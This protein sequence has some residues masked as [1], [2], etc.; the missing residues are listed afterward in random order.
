MSGP[1][2]RHGI[3]AEAPP[4][5]SLHRTRPAARRHRRSARRTAAERRPAD[6]RTGPTTV[7]QASGRTAGGERG[8]RHRPSAGSGGPVTP[9]ARLAGRHTAGTPRRASGRRDGSTEVLGRCADDR[10]TRP[11]S[12][13]TSPDSPSTQQRQRRPPAPSNAA[14][15]DRTPRDRAVGRESHRPDRGRSAGVTPV[16]PAGRPVVTPIGPGP[17]G[18]SSNRPD[19]GRAAGSHTY[20]PGPGARE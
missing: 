9:T 6:T 8:R 2:G 7:R 16:G 4:R 1:E 11:A 12:G 10:A 15:T 17:V 18:R 20:R 13:D 19:R 3:A 5:P 14:P